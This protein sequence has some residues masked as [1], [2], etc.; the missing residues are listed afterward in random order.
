MPTESICSFCDRESFA[1]QIIQET[2]DV[3]V[4]HA[5]RPLAPGHVLILPKRHQADLASLTPGEGMVLMQLVQSYSQVLQRAFSNTGL[6]IFSNIGTSAG[7]TI[8]HLHIHLV[9]RFDEEKQSPFQIL[10]SP[11]LHKA[12]ERLSPEELERQ[13]KMIKQAF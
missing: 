11:E 12:L 8:P 7:Q 3:F 1:S 10:Q 13:I 2:E 4:I 6:N 5:R 9:P